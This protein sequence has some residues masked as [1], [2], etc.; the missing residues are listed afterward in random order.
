MS[1]YNFDY[2][3]NDYKTPPI[4]YNMA[5]SHFG[6]KEFSLDTCCT[7]EN[8]PAKRYFKK[9]EIDGLKADWE[10]VNWCN[11]PFNECKKWIEKAFTE[12]KK[13]NKTAMLIPVRTETEYWHKYIL[14]NP[15][16]KIAWLRKGY[17]F[18]NA[19]NQEMGIFKN[20]L[21]LVYFESAPNYEQLKF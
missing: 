8:I 11:P 3:A 2:I 13:G 16:V 7:D 17:K 12:S 14:F 6:I 21:A 19:Q 4:L 1:K 9:S 18:L 20:A 10:F 5:L 15:E